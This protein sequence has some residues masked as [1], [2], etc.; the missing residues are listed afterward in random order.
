MQLLSQIPKLPHEVPPLH[1]GSFARC[2]PLA[3]FR[4]Q[5]ACSLL[6]QLVALNPVFIRKV[7]EAGF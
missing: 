5:H 1:L 6:L 2:L 7:V 3:L 4:C